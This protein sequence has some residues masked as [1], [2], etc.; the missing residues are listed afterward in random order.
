MR[1]HISKRR[2]LT[3]ASLCLLS[4]ATGAQA[5]LEATEGAVKAAFLHRFTSFIEWPAQTR[6]KDSIVIGVLNADEV[7]SELTRYVA[8]RKS[9][10]AVR[11]IE[12][13]DD[14]QGVHVLF[15]GARENARLS[16]IIAALRNLPVLVVTE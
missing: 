15:I 1:V 11:H 4:F 14:M 6:A 5:Q 9:S 12:S 3:W 13:S 10:I 7:E 16:K 2:L 8:A